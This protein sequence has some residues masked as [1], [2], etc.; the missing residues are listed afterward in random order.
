M[1]DVLVVGGGI[2]GSMAAVG[3]ARLGAKVLM[4]EQYGFLGGMLTAGGVGPMM[5]FHAGKEQV[6]KGPTGEL[7][8]RLVKKGKSPGH[9]FDTNL[10]TYSV[11]PFDAEG[12]KL[13]L[14]EMLLESGVQIL[15]H[16]MLAGVSVKD[17]KIES[18]K[19]CN[20][21]GLTNIKA[22]IYIDATGDADLSAWSGVD[23]TVGR[24]SDGLCQPMTMNI[25]ARCIDIS[26]IRTYIKENAAEE[27]PQYIGKTNLLDNAQRLSIGGYKKTYQQAKEKGIFQTDLKNRTDILFFET[28]YPNEVIINTTAVLGHSSIDPWSLSTAEIEARKQVDELTYFLKT[29]VPGFENMEVAYSGPMIGIRSS[30][31][32]NGLYKLTL[33]DLL[34]TKIFDDT[35]AHGGYPVD[36]HDPEGKDDSN[37]DFYKIVENQLQSGECYQIPYRCLVNNVIANLITVGRSISA[38]FEAQGAIRVSPIA[39][40]I[41]HSGGVAAGLAAKSA[42][43]AR[44]VSIATLR[45]TLKQQGAYLK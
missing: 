16:T 25:K 22:K 21:S 10:Y 33:N 2:S 11:T 26:K 39:G 9:I 19:V 36:V 8:V 17:D 45:E 32:I 20:K 12:M 29:Y 27:F 18:I 37:R 3:A 6:V 15:Y 44:D 38:T 40:A 4:V 28:N 42:V 14:E 41:G 23:F 43:N 13:E 1:Y 7:I 24:A 5:S 35:I 31:Q 30:R 34:Q